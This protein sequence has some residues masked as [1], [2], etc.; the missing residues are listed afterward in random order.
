MTVKELL[1]ETEYRYLSVVYN[2]PRA[3][4]TNLDT[5]VLAVHKNFHGIILVFRNRNNQ[6]NAYSLSKGAGFVSY[7]SWTKLSAEALDPVW[8]LEKI[9]DLNDEDHSAL[10]KTAKAK[11]G[12]YLGAIVCE[13]ERNYKHRIVYYIYRKKAGLWACTISSEGTRPRRASMKNLPLEN[14]VGRYSIEHNLS[15]E[16]F[17]ELRGLKVLAH[18]A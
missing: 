18:L 16:V 1:D 2:H 17:E 14:R 9:E 10:I 6:L 15:K 7:P 12:E 8:A 13:C 4:L 11:Q 5:E 3:I